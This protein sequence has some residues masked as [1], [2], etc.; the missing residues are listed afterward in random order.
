[1]KK[2]LPLLFLSILF[3]GCKKETTYCWQCKTYAVATEVTSTS[4]KT[5]SSG[6]TES[7]VCD[8][9]PEEIEDLIK[10]TKTLSTG[11]SGNV[12]LEQKTFMTCI[13]Q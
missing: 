5:I 3:T 6:N 12:T 7:E 4:R 11:I 10:A 8:K 9:T 1:M 13:K 2:I